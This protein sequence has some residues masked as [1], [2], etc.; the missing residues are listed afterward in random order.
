MKRFV[1]QRANGTNDTFASKWKN[2]WEVCKEK[3]LQKENE[4]TSELSHKVQ[5]KNV[6][7]ISHLLLS[8]SLFF[9]TNATQKGNWE[10][11]KKA[12]SLCHTK[13]WTRSSERAQTQSSSFALQTIRENHLQTQKKET[14]CETTRINKKQSL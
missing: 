1:T 11:Q 7:S 9:V 12:K 5:S 4:W 10:K 6:A 3:L 14:K 8:E 2:L 13:V